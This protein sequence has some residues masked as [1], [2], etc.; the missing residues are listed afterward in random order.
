MTTQAQ[1]LKML[2]SVQ[3]WNLWRKANPNLLP[4][5]RGV[6]LSYRNL[7]GINF[8]GVNL[9]EA[10]LRGASLNNANCAGANFHRADLT[11]V[12]MKDAE[13]HKA[14]LSD[15]N[16]YQA[17]FNGSD[18]SQATICNSN[19]TEA[20]MSGC[21]FIKTDLTDSK[22]NQA[23]LRQSYFTEAVLVGTKFIEANLTQVDLS[24][25]NAK[26]AQFTGANLTGVTIEDWIIDENTQMDSVFC[27]H[28]YPQL[29]EKIDL[30]SGNVNAFDSF[31]MNDKER[32][33]LSQDEVVNSFPN[34]NVSGAN[35]LNNI[36]QTD[37]YFEV[38]IK[39]SQEI[40]NTSHKPV[41]L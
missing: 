33:N 25:V 35:G 41:N 8:K 10:N 38:A 13:L 24:N 37:N 32:D 12:T 39:R 3:K 21:Y 31:V 7:D 19:L 28:F 23:D 26:S 4:E 18:L 5:L 1:H 29:H 34:S 22:L 17:V 15:A 16:L 11:K 20:Q 6:D 14:S 9:R 36:R 2:T 27:D 30:N 40:W